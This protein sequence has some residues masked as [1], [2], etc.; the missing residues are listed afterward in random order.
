MSEQP[1]YEQLKFDAS[2][3]VPTDAETD[4]AAV[5]D[6]QNWDSARV[7]ETGVPN[8]TS[9]SPGDIYRINNGLG[10]RGTR[11]GSEDDNPLDETDREA[12]KSG[13]ELA[14]SLSHPEP[15]TPEPAPPNTEDDPSLD[16]GRPF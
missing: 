16:P 5:A 12:G 1:D 2:A 11:E 3:V 4:V 10:P 8:P 9:A 6:D 15:A 14:R 13:L 7:N